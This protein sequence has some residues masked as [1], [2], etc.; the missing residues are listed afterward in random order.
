MKTIIIV[1]ILLDIGYILSNNYYYYINSG[2]PQTLQSPASG[3]NYF[4]VLPMKP[5]NKVFIALTHNKVTS[6]FQL[7][8]VHEFSSY[9]ESYRQSSVSNLL[10]NKAYT[11][12]TLDDKSV[13]SFS[14]KITESDTK[15]FGIELKV[16]SNLKYLTV[17]LL[18]GENSYNIIADSSN[19]FR[20]LVTGIPYFYYIT[21]NVKQ[22]FTININTDCTT[23]KFLDELNIYEYKNKKEKE[24]IL[25]KKTVEFKKGQ[26][27]IDLYLT[28]IV[29][30]QNTK[31]VAFEVMPYY[32]LDYITV[33]IT[34]NITPS[35]PSSP[36]SSSSFSIGSIS[37]IIA[38]SVIV[39]SAIIIVIVI[40]IK[41]RRNK[42]NNMSSNNMEPL[43]PQN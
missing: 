32:N 33:K 39:V 5:N 22:N 21:A 18:L 14:F 4:F 42:V 25:S 1:I 29:S 13:T 19:V 35:S 27:Q 37:L 23:N 38:I 6:F 3:H 34:N 24:L 10:S 15:Y 12:K 30:K 2:E 16:P 7:L 41:K 31:Y 9:S 43:Y 40:Y 8:K 20:S 36:S 28:Y 26:N 11:K 17:Y